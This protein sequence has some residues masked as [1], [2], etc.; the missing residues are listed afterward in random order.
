LNYSESLQNRFA[1][2]RKALLSSAG[3]EA[4]IRVNMYYATKGNIN[5]IHTNVR[6][7]TNDLKNEISKLAT[8]SD[9]SISFLGAAELIELSRKP[10]TY[11]R[12]LL[13]EQSLTSDTGDSFAC[14]VRL[15]DF[16]SFLTNEYGNINR[17]LFDANV[18][19]FQGNTEVNNSIK[20]KLSNLNEDD[21][22]WY[23]NGITLVSSF[24]DPK[25]K[26]LN[27]K[28]PLLI[29]GL[30]TS[31]VIFS[32]FHEH[33]NS[34]QFDRLK[35][36][37]VFVKIVVPPSEAIRDEIIK[38]TNSQTTIPKPYLR[39]MDN[40]HRNIE[41]HLKSIGIF[42]ERRKNQYK[43]LGK[44]R[45]T[46]VTLSEA[47]QALMAAILFRG[48]DA[49]GRPNSLLKSDEDYRRLFSE[50]YHLNTFSTIILANRR[51]MSRIPVLFPGESTNF[52]NNIVVHAL[53]FVSAQA[54]DTSS[55][56]AAEWANKNLAD[57]E[58]DIA[59][60]KVVEIFRR[61]G[62]T[63]KIAKNR[64]F[65]EKVNLIARGL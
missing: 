63:D 4:K 33:G 23:N 24:V 36:K 41:D 26:T 29:N 9:V 48:A 42:Y 12:K 22:W 38:A 60:C 55:Q 50:K 46:I 31:S 28:D 49:R 6:A 18:R 47:A 13:V 1:I 64:Q 39:G 2:A 54:Y 32:Y 16:V 7:A 57:D 56:A 65:G 5:T 8:T 15:S 44:S 59:I 17:S 43:V 61:E 20:Q 14:L 37:I 35:N 52:R 58:T 40:V 3:R 62:G 10:K 27:L 45:S 21:F 34:P 51:V 53:S 19:D 11:E 25:G 30:Q